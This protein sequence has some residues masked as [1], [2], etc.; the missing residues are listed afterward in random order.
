M[1]DETQKDEDR[2]PNPTVS[3]LVRCWEEPRTDRQETPVLRCFL[4]NLRTG[5]ERYLNDPQ[6][7]GETILHSLKWNTEA[8]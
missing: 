1:N 5:E 7:V 3:F 8:T 2:E 4:R 6:R